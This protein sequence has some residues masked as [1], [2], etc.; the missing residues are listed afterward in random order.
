MLRCWGARC[1]PFWVLGYFF[2]L[3]FMILVACFAQGVRYHP[4]LLS[5]CVLHG[6]NANARSLVMK[7]W[8]RGLLGC[9]WL[10]SSERGIK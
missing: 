5:K 9:C 3:F 1:R 6:G 7:R 4:P 8:K 2:L 10:C